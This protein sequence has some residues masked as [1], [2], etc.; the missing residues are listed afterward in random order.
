MLHSTAW[1]YV[2]LRGAAWCCV[3]LRGAAWCCVVLRGAAWCCVVLRGAAW[4]CVVLRGAAWCCVV[5][6]AAWCCVLH[7]V[8]LLCDDMDGTLMLFRMGRLCTFLSFYTATSLWVSWLYVHLLST[9]PG[10]SLC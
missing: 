5:L 4:C 7:G 6:R 8:G 2:V 3:V 10:G 1:C 9:A